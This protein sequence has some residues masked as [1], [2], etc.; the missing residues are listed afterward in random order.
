MHFKL[1]TTQKLNKQK[2][3]RLWTLFDFSCSQEKKPIGIILQEPCFLDGRIERTLI[4]VYNFI[5]EKGVC[6]VKFNQIYFFNSITIPKENFKKYENILEKLNRENKN[7]FQNITDNIEYIID[8]RGKL[9][10]QS[11]IV[12]TNFDS[13]L[14]NKKVLYFCSKKNKIYPG[15]RNGKLKTIRRFC[16]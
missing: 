9:S 13:I 3:A 1:K 10:N 14:K 2:V 16:P 4:D 7:E 8:G 12:K 5:H 11:K 6:G 15:D